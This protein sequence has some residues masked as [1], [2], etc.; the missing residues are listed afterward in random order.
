MSDS[1]LDPVTATHSLLAQT[2]QHLQALLQRY[3]AQTQ[4]QPRSAHTPPNPTLGASY[5]GQIDRLST[6]V[7]KLEQRI[8]TIAAF[9]LVSRGK[10]AVLNGLLGQKLLETGPINGVTRWPQTVRWSGPQLGGFQVDL[11]DTPGLD[12]IEGQS[13][14]AM[15]KTVAQQTDLILFI[16][17]GDVTRTE[18]EAIQTLLQFQKPIL[19][20]FNKTDLYPVTDRAE[21]LAKLRQF[22]VNQ[23]ETAESLT[24][25]TADVLPVAAEPAPLQVRIEDATGT[26]TQTWETPAAQMGELADRLSQILLQE[27]E[28]LLALN[29]L[30]QARSAAETLAQ[31]QIQTQNEQAEQDLSRVVWTKAAAIA[32]CPVGLGDLAVGAV[33]DLVAVRTLAQRYGLPMTRHRVGR[34]WQRWLAS[35]AIL[36]LGEGLSQGFLGLSLGESGLAAW[37]GAGLVQG[38][39]AAYGGYQVG[40][41]AQVYLQE[42]CTWGPEGASWLIEGILCQATPQGVIARLRQLGAG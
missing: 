4:A 37:G 2:Q 23:G 41:S 25:S 19:L 36:L 8:V 29:A 34:L 28:Q 33:L 30:V 18:Y 10:S 32:L 7:H 26:V 12:E 3:Q 24:L 42:G 22:L 13:R 14:T 38:L 21:I 35:G 15:A 5:Q 6:L 27:G 16:V 31:V 39:A 9:G 20:V 1:R 40:R 11:V 17:A